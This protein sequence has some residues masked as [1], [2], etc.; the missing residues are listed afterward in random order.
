MLLA[1]LSINSTSQWSSSSVRP[2]LSLSLGL[3]NNTLYGPYADLRDLAWLGFLTQEGRHAGSLEAPIIRLDTLS[4]GPEALFY[5][6][7]P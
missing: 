1:G 7:T 6:A 3:A 5:Q 2:V 4:A